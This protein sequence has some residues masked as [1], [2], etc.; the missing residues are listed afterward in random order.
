MERV[1][2]VRIVGAGSRPPSDGKATRRLALALLE[3]SPRVMAAA[4]GLCRVDARGW[5]RRGGEEALARTLRG[6]AREAGFAVRVG[7]A[8]T[9]VTADA[10]AGLE[11]EGIRIVPPG[12]DRAFLAPLPLALLPLEPELR[13]SLRALG[14]RRVGELAA[15]GRA[16]LEARFGPAGLRAHRRARGEDDRLFRP[17]SPEDPPEVRLELEGST[18][19]VEP[20]LFVLRHLLHRLCG[21]LAAE[22]RC[23]GRLRLRLEL[24]RGGAREVEVAPARPTRREGLLFD[25]CRA[26]LERSAGEGRLPDAVATLALAATERA[27]VDVRQGDLFVSGMRDPLAAAGVL[28]RLRARLG[29]EGVARPAPRRTHRPEGRSAW[30]SVEGGEGSGSDAGRSGDTGEGSA[31]P[32]VLRLLPEPRV[33]EVAS[34]AGRP[35]EVREGGRRHEVAAAEGPERLSGEWWRD[36]FRREYWRVCTDAGE[37]LWIFREVRRE[38]D[39]W[40]LHG[41]WD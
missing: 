21:E 1:A 26:A 11:G 8:D 32:G 41:W 40:R 31:L 2:S 29:E 4:P 36:P 6:A 13:E 7:V 38:G 35:V 10:A 30:A 24:E 34:E 3:G 25:L 28:S 37:L 18:R 19:S 23:A 15:L 17:L 39:D 27:W 33:V 14:I 22:A 5:G 12:G 20:L 9:P 16:G